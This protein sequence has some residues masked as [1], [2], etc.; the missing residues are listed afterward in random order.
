MSELPITPDNQTSF[1]I[2]RHFSGIDDDGNTYLLMRSDPEAPF[3]F[4]KDVNEAFLEVRS[5]AG[6]V[7]TRS[8]LSGIDFEPTP[9]L[10]LLDFETGELL[11]RDATGLKLGEK[12]LSELTDEEFAQTT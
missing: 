2:D 9:G 5:K 1:A 10:T 12:A 11:T 8:L 4:E 6:S 7:A 3:N